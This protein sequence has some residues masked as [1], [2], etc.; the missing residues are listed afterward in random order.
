MPSLWPR[1]S[2]CRTLHTLPPHGRPELWGPGKRYGTC[3]NLFRFDENV[4]RQVH[5][6]G[7]T[8]PTTAR[9]CHQEG[10]GVLSLDGLSH[11]R[12]RARWVEPCG[13]FW[14]T[15]MGV[16]A[17]CRLTVSYSRATYES[18]MHRLCVLS[19]PSSPFNGTSRLDTH[20]G[21]TPFPSSPKCPGNSQRS[22]EFP[23]ERHMSVTGG[24]QERHRSVTGASQ[25]RHRS[26]PGVTQ[27]FPGFPR[28]SQAFP[29]LPIVATNVVS[30]RR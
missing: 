14:M 20:M 2:P 28:L 22:Q 12:G 25:E 30:P 3:K 26:V 29:E 10:D 27:D 5:N 23:Q 7:G 9:P 19:C 13:C 8:V 15:R 18:S 4:L 21:G 17:R 1:T 24:S 6:C 16:A 11:G